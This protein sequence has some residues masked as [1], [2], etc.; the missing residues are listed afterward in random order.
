MST[1]LTNFMKLCAVEKKIDRRGAS[2]GVARASVSRFL[3]GAS[4]ILLVVSVAGDVCGEPPTSSACIL[5]AEPVGST[6]THV[7]RA[8][9][10]PGLRCQ[11]HT[12]RTTQPPFARTYR[13]EL[14]LAR[15]TRPLQP[16][17]RDMRRVSAPGP[18]NVS[19]LL[20][21]TV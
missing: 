1:E 14:A 6:R 5:C 18:L 15:A 19:S 10:T 21:S 17:P 3:L 7:P 11:R 2:M 9:S 4:S 16:S 12:A 20:D 13:R 8:Q